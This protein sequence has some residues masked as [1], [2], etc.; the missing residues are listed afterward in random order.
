[1][2]T[3]GPPSYS[4]AEITNRH[5]LRRE[6]AK[7]QVNQDATYCVHYSSI[8]EILNSLDLAD[9]IARY[10]KGDLTQIEYLHQ[11][12][13][14]T[15]QDPADLW[16]RKQEPTTRKPGFG[17]FQCSGIGE[18]EED[19][20][21]D[22]SKNRTEPR[23]KR[24]RECRMAEI[25]ETKLILPDGSIS[26]H[27]VIRAPLIRN[28]YPDGTIEEIGDLPSDFR[29]EQHDNDILMDG[30]SGSRVWRIPNYLFERLFLRLADSSTNELLPR[31]IALLNENGD[32]IV[33]LVNIGMFSM[34]S[35]DGGD[36][37]IG[38]ELTSQE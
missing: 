5:R 21:I 19:G 1:M 7:A 9:R 20:C 25:E 17:Q 37:I 31:S 28:T 11:V 24:K 30:L 8:R 6:A 33:D 29:A 35:A 22:R 10:P 2:C 34:F 13:A 12:P 38:H 26:K 27:R 14:N 23:R 36:I 16:L 32:T 15:P 18:K 3:H 4:E